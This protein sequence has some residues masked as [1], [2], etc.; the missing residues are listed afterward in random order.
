MALIVECWVTPDLYD[1][2]PTCICCSCRTKAVVADGSEEDGHSGEL[3]TWDPTLVSYREG[4]NDKENGKNK[5]K[6][7]FQVVPAKVGLCLLHVKARLE[8][9][10]QRC[11]GSEVLPG[12]QKQWEKK[13]VESR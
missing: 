5:V 11:E 13:E 6:V 1:D 2:C 10:Q 4:E 3:R 7:W 8:T 9:R 12:L